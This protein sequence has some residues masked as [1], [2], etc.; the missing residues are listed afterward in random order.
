MVMSSSAKS[1]QR[2][3]RESEV[4]SP[5][6]WEI[7]EAALGFGELDPRRRETLQRRLRLM[8][9]KYYKPWSRVQLN[10]V[11]PAH[12]RRALGV[13]KQHA[14]TLHAYLAYQPEVP[15]PTD[16]LSE[17]EDLAMGL[18]LFDFAFMVPRCRRRALTNS[19][20]ELIEI[21]DLGLQSLPVDKG[22]RPRN[23]GLQG[24]IFELADLYWQ[25]TGRVPGIS[26]NNYE[27][28]YRGPLL[29]LVKGVLR[30]FAPNLLKDDNAL[31]GDIRRV[32]KWWR[33]ARLGIGKTSDQPRWVLAIF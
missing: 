7:I 19:L 24:I 26:L 16:E 32:L 5:E 9:S 33:K 31:A 13:L 22:G 11:R 30:V 12:W 29:R 6:D 8:V 23:E 28:Q 25:S 2:A 27:Q 15:W 17:L 4:G 1:P 18:F 14:D 20:A 10:E 3:P 21:L